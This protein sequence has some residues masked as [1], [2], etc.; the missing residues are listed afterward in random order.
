M[1][2]SATS[3]RFWNTSRDSDSTTSP[4]SL[5]HYSTALSE[6]K[7]F[8]ISNLRPLW[9]Q[10]CFTAWTSHSLDPLQWDERR[11]EKGPGRRTWLE[12][13]VQS[14]VLE[15]TLTLLAAGREKGLFARMYSY[16]LVNSHSI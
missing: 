3:K 15:Y 2:L 5:C 4:G 11:I 12:G 10:L 7:F 1:S 9:S 13:G 16:L 6:K 8:L 14:R